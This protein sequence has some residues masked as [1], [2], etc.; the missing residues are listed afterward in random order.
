MIYLLLVISAAIAQGPLPTTLPPKTEPVAQSTLE[1]EWEVVDEAESYEIKLTPKN[2]G[3]PLTFTS[4]E[5]KLSKLVPSGVYILQVRS[6]EK[7]TGYMGA[8]SEPA[9]IEVASKNIDLL[10]PKD[11]EV[12]PEPL[13]KRKIITFE[14]APVA[15]AKVY[16]LRIWD[17]DPAKAK[18]FT[19][20]NTK[21]QLDLPAARIY[22]WQVTVEDESSIKYQTA[23]KTYSFSL[24]GKQLIKPILQPKVL[25]NKLAKWSESPGAENY[26]GKVQYRALDET[27]FRTLLHRPDLKDTK[28]DFKKLKPGIYKIQVT[29]HAKNRVS[30]ETG[31]LEFTVKPTEVELVRILSMSSGLKKP[32]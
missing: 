25:G 20:R 18:D 10:S 24:L 14:W 2:G 32:D 21:K 7:G 26:E 31:E 4:T 28:W 11:K 19:T 22:H 30:S 12:I 13:E 15:G 9:A 23:G 27:D 8:W 1:L 16:N 29:A 17:E 6:K 3:I 5:P